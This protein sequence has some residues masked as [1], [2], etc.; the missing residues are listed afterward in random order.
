MRI[1][2]LAILLAVA[3]LVDGTVTA[4]VAIGAV[5]PD[6]FLAALFVWLVLNRGT[7]VVVGASALGLACDLSAGSRLGIVTLVY[8][9]AGAACAWFDDERPASRLSRRAVVTGLSVATP[10]AL[11]IILVLT[12]NANAAWARSCLQGAIVG[13][14]SVACALPIVLAW[15]W[16]GELWGS[17]HVTDEF[18][19]NRRATMF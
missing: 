2:G 1:I 6:G 19:G 3:A 4:R 9:L 5:V 8:S 18:G 11:A 17:A 12:G 10:V 13:G 14:Y 15:R 7:W 16:C